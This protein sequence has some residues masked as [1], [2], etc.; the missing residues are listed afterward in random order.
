MSTNK[1]LSLYDYLGYAA[2][3]EL[4]EQVAAYAKLRKASYSVRYVS[5]PKYKGNVMLYDK[6][7]LDE[8][9]KVQKIFT[10]QTDYTEVN[11]Q[12]MED[13]FNKSYNKEKVI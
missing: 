10:D 4:G 5:N 13:S 9:F 12:L 6:E 11:T 1:M 7:F 3:N 8:Y 2:G